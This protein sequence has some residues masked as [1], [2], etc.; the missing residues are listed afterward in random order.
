MIQ[1]LVAACFAVA[2]TAHAMAADEPK[3]LEDARA[4]EAGSL[5]ANALSSKDGWFKAKVPGKS[6]VPIEKEKGSYSIEIDIGADAN[7]NCEVYPDGIDLAH[8]LRKTAQNTFE[9]IEKVQGKIEVRELESTDA[10]AHGDVPYLQ[11]QWVYLLAEGKQLGGLKQVSLRK[12]DHGIYCSHEALGYAKTFA[13]VA[14]AFAM[15]FEAKSEELPPYYTEI[16]TSTLGGNKIGV[17]TMI[18][19][20]DAEGDIQA[21]H[22]NALLLPLENGAVTTEDSYQTEWTDQD[23]AMI[24]AL[25]FSSTD[26]EV[27]A[28]AKLQ[29]KDGDWVIEGEFQGKKIAHKLAAGAEPGSLLGQMLELRKLLASDKPVGAQHSSPM[30]T[31]ADL[32]KLID[33]KTKVLARRDARSFTAVGDIAGMKIDLVLDP[34]GS[35]HSAQMRI[36]PQVVKMERIYQQGIP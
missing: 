6:T 33:V 5:Q 20:R 36:G 7:I 14:K 15:T 10:G 34:N 27:D 2:L 17:A 12:K 21:R 13:A 16:L 18:L 4:R 3:W 24:N 22:S 35:A 30:W 1:R 19:A 32:S 28:D 23:G 29:L 26:G 25:Q 31:E 8:V 11:T 9:N